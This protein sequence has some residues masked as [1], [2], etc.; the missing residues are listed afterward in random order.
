MCV[1]PLVIVHF[2]SFEKKM[3]NNLPRLP[4]I[5][6]GNWA[7]VCYS[8]GWFYLATGY[9]LRLFRVPAAGCKLR[10]SQFPAAGYKLRLTPSYGWFEFRWLDTGCGRLRPGAG[11]SSSSWIWVTADFILRLTRGPATGY[12]LRLI[13]SHGWLQ[14]AADSFLWLTRV[15]RLGS[16]CSWPIL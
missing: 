14:V 15:R 6:I 12:D 16:N 8:C 4:R 13:P 7:A 1:R 10:Q 3:M 11:L 2:D 9:E 5:S